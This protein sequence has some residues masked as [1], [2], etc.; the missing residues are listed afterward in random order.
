[1]SE[2]LK[3]A[4]DVQKCIAVLWPSFIVSGIATILFFT[5]FDPHDF[6]HWEISRLGA[7]SLGFFMFWL[8]NITSS[9]F[10]LYFNLPVKCIPVGEKDE[11]DKAE[12]SETGKA[13]DA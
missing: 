8:M 1:M 11:K 7:Y 3:C 6:L 13:P 9:L 5:A 12:Q 2:S 10:T 4:P